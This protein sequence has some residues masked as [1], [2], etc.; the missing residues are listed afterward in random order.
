MLVLKAMSN[1]LDRPR[2]GFQ[3][4]KRLG[5]AVIRNRVKRRLREAVRLTSVKTGWDI[6]FI[7]RRDA[8]NANYHQLKRATEDLLNKA[9][10]LAGSTSPPSVP[11]IDRGRSESAAY[12]ES[13]EALAPSSALGEA[14]E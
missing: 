8:A 13:K 9:R 7:A 1:H 2:F 14:A 6:V 3:V 5:G 12:G 11:K 4:G 10:L